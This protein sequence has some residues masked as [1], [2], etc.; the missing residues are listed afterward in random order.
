[1]LK[2]APYNKLPTRPEYITKVMKMLE[3]NPESRPVD[4]ERKTGLTRTQVMCTLE[5]LLKED[6]I[7]VINGSS[8]RYRLTE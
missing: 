1:M 8:R 6:Q 7:K 3:K 5:H 4:I 2:L